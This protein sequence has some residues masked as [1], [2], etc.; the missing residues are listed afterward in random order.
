MNS[1]LPMF[2][3]VHQEQ[4]RDICILWVIIGDPCVKNGCPQSQQK[5]RGWIGVG[6]DYIGQ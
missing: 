4:F 5:K 2:N 1:M 6:R 3:H